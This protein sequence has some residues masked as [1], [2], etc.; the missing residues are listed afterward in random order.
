MQKTIIIIIVLCLTSCSLLK[1]RLIDVPTGS[2]ANTIIPGDKLVMT[3]EVGEVRRGDIVVFK[4]PLDPKVLYVKRIIGLPGEEILVRGTEV[5]VNGNPLPEQHV[6]IKLI[7]NKYGI[8]PVVRT[9]PAPPNARWKVFYDEIDTTGDDHLSPG[10]K[11]GVRQPLRIPAGHYFVMGD[12]RD[13]AL[14]SRFW[15]IVPAANIVGKPTLIYSSI[16]KSVNPPKERPERA[17]IKIQ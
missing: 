12:S 10:M 13:N 6:F 8:L 5:L 2:M 1:T 11:Y 9:D 4:L 15:G 16:D 17:G 14:D 3:T 7:D